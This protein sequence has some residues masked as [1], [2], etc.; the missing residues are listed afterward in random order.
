MRRALHSRITFTLVLALVFVG[1]AGVASAQQ[2]V[3][4][5][6]NDGFPG[7]PTLLY[8]LTMTQPTG[9]T[10]TVVGTAT[11]G[12]ATR[13]VTGGGVLV[14]GQFE[15]SLRSTDI[16]TPSQGGGPALLVH[17]THV[18]INGPGFTSGTFESAH[19]RYFES[20]Q[21][22]GQTLNL[23]DGTVTVVACPPLG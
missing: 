10:A 5:D 15:L 20:N 21:G 11:Q 18:E 22:I 13:I 17:S 12:N 1:I 9:T 6:L 7:S 8:R 16:N 4:L 23:T 2:Q 3:C 14:G 19:V